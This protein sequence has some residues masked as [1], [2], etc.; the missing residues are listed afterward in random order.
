[1]VTDWSGY[2]KNVNLVQ[3]IPL[4]GRLSMLATELAITARKYDVVYAN[5]QKAFTLGA[6]AAAMARRPLIWHLHDVISGTGFGRRQ[7]RV[8]ISLANHFAGAVIA[9][10]GAAVTSFVAEGGRTALARAVPNGIEVHKS[11]ILKAK[12]R[13]ALDLP[14]GP[15]IGVFSRLCPWKGQH[16]VLRALHQLPGVRLVIAGSALFGEDAY[17]ASLRSLVS[18]LKLSDRVTFLG[19]RSDISQLMEAVDVVVHP[20]VLPEAFGLTLVEAMGVGTPVVA[21]TAG[22]SE[23]L[24]GAGEAGILVPPGDERAIASA[25]RKI[26][27]Y[28]GAVEAQ[29]ERAMI[30][31]RSYTVDK[32]RRAIFAVIE[33]VAAG[34]KR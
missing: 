28:P 14:Q 9:P 6:I 8:Q 24:L 13:E 22:A 34:P 4:C 26:L 31:A 19:Q 32:M 30:L 1:L 16:I 12:L 20:S 2:T 23:E 10:S 11:A 33:S 21:T 3:V 18:K 7:I 25:V 15:L 27:D 5:S 29:L 17:A